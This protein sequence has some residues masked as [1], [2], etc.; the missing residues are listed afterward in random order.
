MSTHLRLNEVSSLDQN[1]QF[2]TMST[3]VEYTGD[4]TMRMQ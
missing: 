1:H 3:T 4:E 2:L